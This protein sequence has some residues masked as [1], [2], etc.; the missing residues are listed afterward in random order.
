MQG[1]A[2]A[3]ALDDWAAQAGTAGDFP[4]GNGCSALIHLARRA[5]ACEF[6][7]YL[8]ARQYATAADHALA[9]LDLVDVLEDQLTVY[10][11]HSEVMH[12]NRTAWH[13]PVVVEPRLFGLL[14]LAAKL[15]RE[16]GGA[17]DITSGPLSKAW[18]F[19]RRQGAIPDDEALAAAL[20]RVGGDA[21]RLDATEQSVR[22]LRPEMEL[23]LGAIGKGY[24]LDRVAEH[25][26]ERGVTSFLLHGGSSSVLARGDRSGG[27]GARSQE[28]EARSHD[29][30]G[31]IVGVVHPEFPQRRLAEIRLRDRAVGTSGSATQFFRHGGKKYGHILDPRTGRPAEGVLATTVVAPTAAEADALATACYVLGEPALDYAANRQNIALL[32]T[33]PGRRTGEVQVDAIGFAPGELTFLE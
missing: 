18:G 26:T 3:A 8:D 20:A 5:M 13:E 21:L 2:A 4:K 29:A 1:R 28:P 19:Y 24:A 23:N 32:L 27:E 9:A 12:V 15:H 17:V 25:L 11:D 16:T 14:E 6:E 7:I 30:G 22:F 31:W 10:R 33:R